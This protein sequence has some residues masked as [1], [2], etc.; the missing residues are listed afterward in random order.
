[1]LRCREIIP[2]VMET[3]VKTGFGEIT[4]EKKPAHWCGKKRISNLGC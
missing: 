3:S 2:L 1:M 4:T